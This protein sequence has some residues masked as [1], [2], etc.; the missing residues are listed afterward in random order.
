MRSSPLPVWRSAVRC[1]FPVAAAA[2][3]AHPAIQSFRDRSPGTVSRASRQLQQNDQTIAQLCGDRLCPRRGG[4]RLPTRPRTAPP[5]A[6]QAASQHPNCLYFTAGVPR[7]VP[8]RLQSPAREAICG[9]AGLHLEP[10]RAERAARAT[11]AGPRLHRPAAHRSLLEAAR[12][13]RGRA[14][15]ASQRPGRQLASPC[16]AR[17]IWVRSLLGHGEPLQLGRH[18]AKN[19]L[20]VRDATAEDDGPRIERG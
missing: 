2:R 1:S 18:V 5:P 7:A 9:G 13:R 14:T 15:R 12:A 19:A 3:A 4:L 11:G 16:S 8:P 17:T 20:V 6:D 10:V